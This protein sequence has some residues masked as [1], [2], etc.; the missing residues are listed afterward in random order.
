MAGAYGNLLRAPGMRGPLVAS[1]VGRLPIGAGTL[2]ILLLVHAAT[3]SFADAGV[4][5]AFMAAGM[6]IGLPQLG[7]LVDRTGQTRVLVASGLLQAAAFVGL[8]A[9]AEADAPLGA[10]CAGAFAAGLVGPPL[11]LCMRGLWA[12]RLADRPELQSAF[13]IESVIVELVF[14]C[15]PL[16]AGGLTAAFSPSVAMLGLAGLVLAGALGFAA[17]EASRTWRGRDPGRRHWAGPLRSPGICAIALASAAFGV[18]Q[19]ALEVTLTA[20]GGAHGSTAIAGPLLSIQAAASLVAGVLYGSRTWRSNPAD[21]FAAMNALLA[22][23]FAPLALA[24]S[25]AGLAPLMV[26]AGLGLAPVTSTLYLLTDRLAPAGTSTEAFGWTITATVV[27]SAA[28]SAL[29]GAVVEGSVRG[30]FLLAFG[31]VCASALAAG[32]ARPVLRS[33]PERGV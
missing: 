29:G 5:G 22:I 10:L 9:L 32:L 20:F 16:L 4:A 25:V 11:G 2:T 1:I 31:G 6:A 24:S 7:R 21:R 19:G 23:G 27:G 26:L 17:T 12:Q 13:A 33:V 14:I 30:G 15:G 18:G 28:G 3:G 8:V